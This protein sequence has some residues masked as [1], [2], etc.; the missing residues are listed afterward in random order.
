M[1]TI[2]GTAAIARLHWTALRAAVKLE[3]VGMKRSRRPSAR[4]IACE[5]LRLPK[6]TGYDKVLKAIDQKMEEL[7]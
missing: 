6:R 7:Q 5:A 3:K 4:T 2:T 1:T